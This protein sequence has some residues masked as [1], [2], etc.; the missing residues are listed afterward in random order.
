M[1]AMWM[2]YINRP[3]RSKALR[4]GCTLAVG[5]CVDCGLRAD[6]PAAAGRPPGRGPDSTDT[7]P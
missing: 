3:A 4:G 5:C 6:P 2:F 7:A 1:Y